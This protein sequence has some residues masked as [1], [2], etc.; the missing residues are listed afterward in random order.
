MKALHS[1]ES[2]KAIGSRNLAY[3]IWGRHCY[4]CGE[5]PR[6]QKNRDNLGIHHIRPRFYQG[7]NYFL[8]YIPLED[9]CHPETHRIID[10][11]LMAELRHGENGKAMKRV[12]SAKPDL[13][14]FM[15]MIELR[16][17][18]LG[19]EAEMRD[20]ARL[21]EE[22]QLT[23]SGVL[24]PRTVTPLIENGQAFLW[25]LYAEKSHPHESQ[26]AS[27]DPFAR[28]RRVMGEHKLGKE[29]QRYAH[30]LEA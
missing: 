22:C 11:R 15:V 20:F 19:R 17:M 7:K 12:G 4:C 3:K 27:E 9:K 1:P 26:D 23:P 6:Q 5:R 13:F 14:Y 16:L 10:A 28:F 2:L 30:M 21:V 29:H 18:K 25:L 24:V 8:N